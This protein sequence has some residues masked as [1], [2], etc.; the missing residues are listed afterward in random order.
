MTV[1]CLAVLLAPEP[2]SPAPQPVAFAQ[3]SAPAAAL[4]LPV[5]TLRP[6]L[7]WAGA[8]LKARPLEAAPYVN[9]GRTLVPVR[10]V[11]ETLG[12]TVTWNGAAREVRIELPGRT[13]RLTPGRAQ[14]SVD[15]RPVPLDVAPGIVSD[16][17][18]VPLRA[19]AEGLGAEVEW[20]DQTRSIVIS[21]LGRR[22]GPLELER[23]ALQLVNL[24]RA[25]Q[26]LRQLEWDEAAATA[27]RLH[28]RD[29]A[30]HGY[31]SHWNR[32]GHLP[33]FR[34]NRA[35]GRDAVSENLATIY[36][37]PG[38][39]N[40][41]Q[42]P[43]WAR[44]LS[45]QDGL[46]KSDGH[47][48]NLLAPEHTHLGVGLAIGPH[49]GT[50]MAQEFVARYGT[51]DAVPERAALGDSVRVS[52]E[53]AGGAAL[54]GIFAAY[55]DRRPM[56]TD[57]LNRTSSYSHPWPPFGRYFPPGYVTDGPVQVTGNRFAASVRLNDQG[58]RGTY[59]IYVTATLP[60]HADP[61]LVSLR[62]VA[63]E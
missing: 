50:Y 43:D 41:F 19:V 45:H 42:A 34:Y 52:G 57:E 40:F 59:Y 54:H 32:D 18:F 12:A 37:Q 2:L 23:Y 7:A 3:S 51:H 26:G 1:V 22:P 31:F 8:G 27:G 30:D 53:L 39:S 47:R 25:A 63:V 24:D 62:T 4:D 28:A 35:G 16:R 10:A 6:G 33:G 48:R 49:G 46:M 38:N 60:G 56:G 15:G 9:V 5:A 13:L 61:Q 11:A 14:M 21:K 20:D 36:F 44:I 55:H 17:T 29:M 58:R